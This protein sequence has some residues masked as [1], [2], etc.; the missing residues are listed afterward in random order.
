MDIRVIDEETGLYYLNAR[1]YDPET[2]R[3]LSPDDPSY[4]DPQVLT[5]LS[6]YAY[7]LNNPVMYTD[8][9]GTSPK[10]WQWLIS[11]ALIVGGAILC[12]VPG[13]QGF[14]VALFVAGGSMMLSNILSAAG[15]DGKFDIVWVRYYSRDRSVIYSI[16]R[17]GGKS[18]R[19]RHRRNRRRLH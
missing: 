1:Y 7:C 15:F 13:G 4:L 5:S 17:I 11:G 19:I 9:T 16:C 14:G 12:L 6:L 3:F 18:D 10:W 2:G 8:R